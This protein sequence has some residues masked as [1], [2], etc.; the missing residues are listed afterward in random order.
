MVSLNN[1]SLLY[2]ASPG[3]D[4]NY[5]PTQPI[6]SKEDNLGWGEEESSD[7]DENLWE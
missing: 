1:E 3:A 2:T 4:G 7:N 6:E 5:D